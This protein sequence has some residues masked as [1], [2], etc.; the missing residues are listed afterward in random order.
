MTTQ[1][2]PQRKLERPEVIWA[3]LES[4]AR[5]DVLTDA[6]RRV[7]VAPST[8]YRECR[9][10]ALFRSLTEQARASG[11]VARERAATTAP[12]PPAPP[13]MATLDIVLPAMAEPSPDLEVYSADGGVAVPATAEP[14]AIV[15]EPP[16]EAVS[17]PV[18]RP[19]R[20]RGFMTSLGSASLV[21]AA[22]RAEL[23]HRD[24]PT[25]SVA[26]GD[27]ALPALVLVSQCFV[28]LALVGN[29]TL[30]LVATGIVVLAVLA[31]LAIVRARRSM[32]I[33]SLAPRQAEADAAAVQV[34]V[35]HDLDW[36]EASIGRPRPGPNDPPR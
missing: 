34:E 20:M 24:R 10:S 28:V 25:T 15:Y 17:A 19:S 36:L 22:R 7:D 29:T 3:L 14:V 4:L 12:A 21:G 13:E 35:R 8:Y 2:A 26:G 5:G 9:R 32:P 1:P 31:V 30:Q 33:A 27:W 16:V 6:L 18:V 11:A 23:T